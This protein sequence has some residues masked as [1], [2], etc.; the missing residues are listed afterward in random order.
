MSDVTCR[1]SFALGTACMRCSKCKA[2]I[3]EYE[4]RKT[5][6][7]SLDGTSVLKMQVTGWQNVAQVNGAVADQAKAEVA[8]LTARLAEVEA[9]RDQALRRENDANVAAFNHLR[10]A[11]AAEAEV[12]RLT[13]Q[14]EQEQAFTRLARVRA[15]VAEAQLATARRDA[16]EEAADVAIRMER[17]M[18]IQDECGYEPFYTP[19]DVARFIR[20]LAQEEP[21]T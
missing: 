14:I 8:R 19:E 7:E 6:R 12:A 20:A 13:V 2:E 4:V 5:V 11:E 1:G 17:E 10:R 16:L 3:E 9:E 18:G 21:T 15:E